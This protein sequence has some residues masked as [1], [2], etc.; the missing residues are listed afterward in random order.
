MKLPKIERLRKHMPWVS[1]AE[2]LS[3]IRELDD[4][5]K[6]LRPLV[7]EGG[8]KV[9]GQA[10]VERRIKGRYPFLVAEG[11]RQALFLVGYHAMHD[12]HDKQPA[13][14]TTGDA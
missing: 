11:L 12:G 10:E 7:E 9:L 8:P 1:E 14:R 13:R 6:F 4:A 3:W 2:L 5:E